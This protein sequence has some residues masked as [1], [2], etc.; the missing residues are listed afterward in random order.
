MELP[1]QFNN[2]NMPY[3][4]SYCLTIKAIGNNLYTPNSHETHSAHMPDSYAASHSMQK[5][6]QHP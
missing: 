2:E 1:N 3:S 6:F 4:T 5:G